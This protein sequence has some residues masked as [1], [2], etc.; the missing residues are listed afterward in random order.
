MLKIKTTEIHN[1]ASDKLSPITERSHG[2]QELTNSHPI[3]EGIDVV[4][5]SRTMDSEDHSKNESNQMENEPEKATDMEVEE[6]IEGR[7]QSGSIS[8]TIS[9]KGAPVLAEV[10]AVVE[11]V[12]AT[13]KYDTD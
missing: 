4:M 9:K 12:T 13:Q 8:L 10:I 5:V 11:V 2:N 1:E 3:I 6:I 7:L